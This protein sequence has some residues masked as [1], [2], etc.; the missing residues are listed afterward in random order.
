MEFNATFIVAFISF[1]IFTFIMNIILYKPI[2]DIVS[3]RKNYIDTNYDKAKDN[4][5]KT[6]TI[7][8]DRKN[9]L[10]KAR[11]GAKEDVDK[12][13]G[14]I[15]NQREEIT[16]KAQ[17]EAKEL[18]EQNRLQSI[19]SS[20]EAKETLKVEIK[21]LAQMISDRFLN[22]EEKIADMDNNLVDKI[23]QE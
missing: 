4:S 23:M 19:N 2:N 7:L 20:N 13:I 3:K 12:K 18:V 16:L 15:K 1:I 17:K 10:A 22:P 21:N 6:K 8:E 14:L 9:Q 11:L 5:E